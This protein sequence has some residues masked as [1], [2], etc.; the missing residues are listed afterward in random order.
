MERFVDL[1]QTALV[2]VGVNLSRRDIRMPEHFLDDAKVGPVAQQVRG[3]TMAQHMRMHVQPD[4]FRSTMDNLPNA[5]RGE[6][7]SVL[8]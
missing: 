4:H 1:L 5:L 7:T 8:I 6:E 3:E 2:D